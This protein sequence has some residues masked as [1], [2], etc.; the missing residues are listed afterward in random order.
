MTDFIKVLTNARSLKAAVR[1]LTLEQLNDGFAKFT[2]IVDERRA[3]AEANKAQEDARKQKIEEMKALLAAE[4]LDVADLVAA[5]GTTDKSATKRAPR[6]AKY[7]Y[8]DESGNEKLWTGQ[9][10]TP[11]VIQKALDA[12]EP[13]EKF[14]I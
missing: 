2:E 5:I 14:S 13:I 4:G 12:G 6:P 11:S 7:K 10:R 9:G 8:I 3:A 1:E